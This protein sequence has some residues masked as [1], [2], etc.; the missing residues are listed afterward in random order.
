MNRS[1]KL[2][3]AIASFGLATTLLSAAG[4]AS[5]RVQS[6]HHNRICEVYITNDTQHGTRVMYRG[7]IKRGQFKTVRGGNGNTIC[8]RRSRVAKRC[9]SGWTAPQ[10]MTDNHSNRT[11]ILDIR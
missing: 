10:C 9:N 8:V 11:K 7:P 6:N 3:L 4:T 5:I 2:P 1:R